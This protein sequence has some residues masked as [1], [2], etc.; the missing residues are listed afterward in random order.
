MKA[1]DRA[2]FYRRNRQDLMIT[3][4]KPHMIMSKP[5]KPIFTQFEQN[6]RVS[7][8]KS[9]NVNRNVNPHMQSNPINPPVVSN[10]S[11]VPRQEVRN[12]TDKCTRFGRA[13]RKPLKFR[14][15]VPK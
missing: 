2:D 6:Q 4:E 5:P 11:N 3:R 14:D 15:Y 12:D 7:Q 13:I 9:K 1:G 8:P 10:A